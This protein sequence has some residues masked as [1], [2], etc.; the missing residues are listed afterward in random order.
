MQSWLRNYL[1]CV[2]VYFG[3]SGA[4][5]YYAYWCFGHRLYG[6]GNMPTP[7]DVYEQMRV[8]MVPAH[9]LP[10]NAVHAMAAAS[11]IRC[12]CSVRPGHLVA[13]ASALLP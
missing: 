12:P 7:G 2:A 13:T 3:I 5:V 8:R 4:W 10:C 6:R 1:A 11:M 9:L